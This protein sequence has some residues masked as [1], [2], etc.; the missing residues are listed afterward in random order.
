MSKR[1]NK[2]DK[3]KVLIFLTDEGIEKRKVAR[4]FILNFN[5]QLMDSIPKGKLKTFFDVAR[6]L[7]ASLDAEL[8]KFQ[9]KPTNE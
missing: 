4:G 2:K 7:D 3:R 1:W 9:L 5:Y 6:K 8:N